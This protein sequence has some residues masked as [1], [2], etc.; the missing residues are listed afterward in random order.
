[1]INLDDIKLGDK[2]S[3]ETKLLFGLG[4]TNNKDNSKKANIKEAKRYLSYEKTGKLSRGKET[5]EIIITDIFPIPLDKV[6]LRV[7]NGGSR[8]NSGNKSE[9]IEDITDLAK[10]LLNEN[11]GCLE[12]TPNEAKVSFCLI[13]NK[14][15]FNISY[16]QDENG[17]DI[18]LPI[19]HYYYY[20]K[21]LF[22]RQIKTLSNRLSKTKEFDIDFSYFTWT[23]TAEKNSWHEK[24]IV[25][26]LEEE[27]IKMIEQKSFDTFKAK[28]N[29]ETSKSS[30]YYNQRLWRKFDKFK[31][32]LFEKKYGEGKKYCKAIVL[33]SVDD[34]DVSRNKQEIINSLKAKYRIKS[35]THILGVKKHSVSDS[36]YIRYIANYSDIDKT[37]LMAEH[38]KLFGKEDWES[39]EMQMIIDDNK[40]K[41][42]QGRILKPQAKKKANKT[43]SNEITQLTVDLDNKYMTFIS[44][45]DSIVEQRDALKDLEVGSEEWIDK[46]I[47]IGVIDKEN[48]Q[49]IE[50]HTNIVE[51]IQTTY[52]NFDE[53]KQAVSNIATAE[54]L[55]ELNCI[56]DTELFFDKAYSFGLIE[57]PKETLERIGKLRQAI[58]DNYIKKIDEGETFNGAIW[59]DEIAIPKDMSSGYI[60]PVNEWNK[61]YKID[62]IDKDNPFND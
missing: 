22:D 52:Y 8:E 10:I 5:N 55:R 26:D 56:E 40:K 38:D 13:S 30:L 6:D 44:S 11:D 54:Q 59:H 15:Y 4:F 19:F 23:W 14:N 57:K 17:N 50:K 46:A 28:N 2:F 60:H 21:S 1:M 34:L 48:F 31:V 12:L 51:V 41:I 37:K 53:I 24:R 3:N 61:I 16:N 49:E 33:S 43:M 32:S 9:L 39:K 25:N 7:S 58:I 18:N 42:E 29:L 62:K 45:I 20:L 35:I 27:F 36:K 47:E